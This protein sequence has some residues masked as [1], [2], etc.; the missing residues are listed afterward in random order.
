VNVHRNTTIDRRAAVGTSSPP[1]RFLATDRGATAI[2][3]A[4]LAALIAAVIVGVVT[5]VG[6]DALDNFTQVSF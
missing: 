1:H 2:E 3:Y 4:I 5:N 6:Q